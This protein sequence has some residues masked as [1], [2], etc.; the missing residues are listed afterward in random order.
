MA[1]PIPSGTSMSINSDLSSGDV[2]DAPYPDL[3]PN[4][5]EAI[6]RKHGLPLG[7]WEALPIRGIVNRVYAC[8]DA[9]LRIPRNEPDA[10]RDTMT[11]SMAVPLAMA[12]GIRTP[13]LLAFDNDR[14]LVPVPFGAYARVHG[15]VILEALPGEAERMTACQK[16]GEDLGRL[17]SVVPRVPDPEGIL[18]FPEPDDPARH[19]ADLQRGGYLAAEEAVWLGRWIDHLRPAFEVTLPEV[20]CHWDVHEL[21]VLVDRAGDPWLIDWGD[22]GYGDPAE[23]FGV[24]PL[25]GIPAM[26]E[27][28]LR[29]REV[30]EGFAGRLL[31]AQLSHGLRRASRPASSTGYAPGPFT[32]FIRLWQFCVDAPEMFQPWLPRR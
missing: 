21:N 14:D 13:D 23:E 6:A 27:G 1:A 17:H 16:L 31:W 7:P 3:T 28:Y 20:F 32:R 12:S 25:A 2:A 22:A 30:D 24:F 15:D 8:E 26:L 29:E 11:E 4:E 19:L 5:L 18:D 9:I 10:I